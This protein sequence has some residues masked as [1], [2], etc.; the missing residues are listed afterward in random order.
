MKTSKQKKSLTRNQ[1]APC[2]AGLFML[3]GILQASASITVSFTAAQVKTAMGI[4]LND[5]TYQWGLWAVRAMPVVT[6]GGY[7]I[8]G[9][10]GATTQTGWGTSVP[11]GAF[12]AAPYTAANSAWFWDASG[13]E[14]SPNPPN[15]LYMIMDKPASTF[16]SYFGN[17]VTAVSDSSSLAFSFTLDP[18]ASWTGI[19]F[20]VDGSKYTLGTE[21][22][23]G[24][25]VADFFGG[26]GGWNGSAWIDTPNGGLSGNS[27]SGYFLPASAVPE[28][29]T[30]IAGALLL[31]PFGMSFLRKLRKTA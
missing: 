31:L 4:P 22:L 28:P 21:A 1:I 27:G 19:Q 17:T 7:S 18:G 12:G 25:W 2:L 24:T 3:A 30:V 13:A 5:A 6:G 11:N 15:P 26:Y 20:V 9:A 8:V 23:P 14:V 29:S 16:T 10:S